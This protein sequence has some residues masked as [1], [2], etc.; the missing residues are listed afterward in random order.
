MADIENVVDRTFD[1]RLADG[2]RQNES[3]KKFTFA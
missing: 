3:V 2:D 1:L